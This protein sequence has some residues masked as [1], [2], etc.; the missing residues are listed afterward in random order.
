MTEIAGLEVVSHFT[1]L[2]SEVDNNGGCE[3][4]MNRR[5]QMARNAVVKL[6]KIWRDCAITKHTKIRLVRTLVFSIFLH[7]AETWTLRQKE[8]KKIDSFEIWCWR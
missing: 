3:K 6:N 8:R 2:G 5:E 4:E 1:Y 7:R